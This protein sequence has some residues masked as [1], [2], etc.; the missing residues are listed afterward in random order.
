MGRSGDA[1]GC[2]RLGRTVRSV[3]GSPRMRGVF[4]F[5]MKNRY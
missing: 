5:E 2:P 1:E 4:S 3:I